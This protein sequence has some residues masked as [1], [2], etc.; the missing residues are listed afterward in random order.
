MNFG[1]LLL[2]T[3]HNRTD[4]LNNT[5]FGTHINVIYWYDSS[6]RTWNNMQKSDYFERGRGYWVHAREEVVWQFL[7]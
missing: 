4:G 6:T 5:E 1:W 2:L 3:N 7:L